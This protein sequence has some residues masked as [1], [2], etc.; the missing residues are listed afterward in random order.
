MTQTRWPV[1]RWV[2][3][4][5]GSMGLA[6]ALSMAGM[7]AQALTPYRRV[8]ELAPVPNAVYQVAL[9]VQAMGQGAGYASTKTGETTR[10]YFDGLKVVAVK[11]PILRRDAVV[12]NS[13]GK[14]VDRKS[15]V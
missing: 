12:W 5:M 3:T 4:G 1:K 9:D 10:Y 14:P 2:R 8:A 6:M 13:Q 11:E 7:D 15:V